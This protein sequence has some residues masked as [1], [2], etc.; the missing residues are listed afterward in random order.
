MD[1][2]LKRILEL[3]GDKRGAKTRFFKALNLNS[4]TLADWQSG[5]T[6]SYL[7]LIPQI[8]DYFNVSADYL[9]KGENESH[10][11]LDDDIDINNIQF[12]LSKAT[13]DPTELTET[14]IED[15]KT[16]VRFIKD[17]RKKNK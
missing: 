2:V 13:G 11:A 1:D 6:S 12:A 17:K 7:K 14:D 8:A 15:V 10:A 9:L 5:K 4:S 3:I 16:F